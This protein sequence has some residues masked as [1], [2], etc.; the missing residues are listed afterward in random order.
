MSTLIRHGLNLNTGWGPFLCVRLSPSK[1][2]ESQQKWKVVDISLW[3]S[4]FLY[5]VQISTKQFWKVLPVSEHLT[6]SLWMN[7]YEVCTT[8]KVE[9]IPN[10]KR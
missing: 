2:K 5:I 10:K 8:K 3:R 6:V 1:Q 4:V 9:W 7:L